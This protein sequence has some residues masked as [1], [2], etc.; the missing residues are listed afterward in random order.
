VAISSDGA[1]MASGSDDNTVKLWDVQKK[2]LIQTFKYNGAVYGG[3]ALST[4]N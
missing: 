4:N 2:Q 3:V 1:I